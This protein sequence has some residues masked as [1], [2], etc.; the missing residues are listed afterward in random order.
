MT[1]AVAM[2]VGAVI[3]AG[4]GG[5]GWWFADRY[6]QQI[7]R[8]VSI[9]LHASRLRPILQDDLGIGDKIEYDMRGDAT[10]A[11]NLTSYGKR[12]EDWRTLVGTFL[13]K[14]LPNSGADTKFLGF[15][16]RVGQGGAR[17]EYERLND[18]RD[19]LR[20]IIDN[21]E[22]YCAKS[23]TL[24]DGVEGLVQLRTDGVAL[25]NRSVG[26]D[27]GSKNFHH[28]FE[29][30][31][32]AVVREMR[33]IGVRSSDIAYFETLDLLPAMKFR[34]AYDERHDKDLRELTEKLQRLMKII[35]RHDQR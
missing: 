31:Q 17:Y 11:Q 20:H 8:K 14:K 29:A 4:V 1:L 28:E 34:H 25:R 12:I 15:R 22:S 7:G 13:A 19:N 30:W 32:K 2:G 5:I 33:S 26:N 3:G 9:S 6:Q 23:S 27:S 16:P 35:Q 10:V 21:L 24:P 18:M